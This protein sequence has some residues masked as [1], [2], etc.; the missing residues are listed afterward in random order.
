[1]L[2][3]LTDGSGLDVTDDNTDGQWSFESDDDSRDD[4]TR[5]DDTRDDDTRDDDT[6][7]LMT[8]LPVAGD[9]SFILDVDQF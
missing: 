7:D 2:C 3:R 9:V 5:D 1:M 6:G 8:D 4:D